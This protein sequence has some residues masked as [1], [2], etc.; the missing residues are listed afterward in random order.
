MQNQLTKYFL[1]TLILSLGFGQ[2][3][4]FDLFGI[5][6]YL[7]DILVALILCLQGRTLKG[8]RL[9]LDIKLILLGLALGWLRAATM[10]PLSSLLVPLLY[11]LR[12]LA[13]LALYYSLRNS[14]FKIHYSYFLISAFVSLCIGMLQ[15]FFMPDMRVFQYLGWD[16]HLNRLILPHFDPTFS[17]VMLGLGLMTAIKFKF[18]YSI[19][20]T[21]YF[22]PAILLTYSRSVWLSLVLTVGYFIKPKKLLILLVP[23]LFVS[24]LLLPKRFG[25]GNN[26]LRT[27]SIESR[28]TSDLTI[29]K[30][31]NWN[32]LTGVGMNTFVLNTSSHATGPN[33]S[34]LYILATCG[35]VGLIGWGIFLRDIYLRSRFKPMIIFILVASLFNNALFYPFVLLWVLLIDSMDPSAA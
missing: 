32:L 21:L 20:H 1:I 28:Y 11:T 2:L 24:I 35:I 19:L 22:I 15:Y 8:Y 14:K 23:I 13:Y 16:D 18:P 7:H 31:L 10:F 4:R 34:Y 3:L 29:T 27:F 26:L 30:D 25:E 5:P 9:Q 6:L 17:A 33:D 12:L